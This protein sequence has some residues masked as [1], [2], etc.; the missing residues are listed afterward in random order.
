M[1]LVF[2]INEVLFDVFNWF[3]SWVPLIEIGIEG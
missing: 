1:E 3:E 2:V